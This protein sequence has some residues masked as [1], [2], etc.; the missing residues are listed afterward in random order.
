MTKKTAV[1]T[2]AERP[3]LTVAEAAQYLGVSR[4][5]GYAA[6]RSGELPSISLG[7]RVV[8]PTS[9]VRKMLGLDDSPPA[10]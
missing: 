5:H 4:S 6:V 10:A 8:V 7:R 3:T 9:A 1:P 2:P